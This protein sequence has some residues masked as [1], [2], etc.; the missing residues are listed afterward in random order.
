MWLESMPKLHSWKWSF[1]CFTQKL[2]CFH[3]CSNST[4]TNIHHFFTSLGK[5]SAYRLFEWITLYSYI[6]HLILTLYDNIQCDCTRSSICLCHKKLP[7]HLTWAKAEFIKL[8]SSPELLVQSSVWNINLAIWWF[9]QYSWQE[10]PHNSHTL[11]DSK[12]NSRR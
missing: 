11:V 8:Q 6:S 9:S 3:I 12:S 5:L 4:T 2:L 1:E 10:I 7:Y